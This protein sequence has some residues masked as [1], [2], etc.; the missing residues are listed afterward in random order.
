MDGHGTGHPEF[1]LNMSGIIGNGIRA[2]LGGLGTFSESWLKAVTTRAQ[3][4]DIN[5]ARTNQEILRRTS[6]YIQT[7]R[8]S[9]YG[10]KYRLRQFTVNPNRRNAGRLREALG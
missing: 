2:L 6:A 1:N 10:L 5:H 9:E 3:R 8:F 4:A 7:L